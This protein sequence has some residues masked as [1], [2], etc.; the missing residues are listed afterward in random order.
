MTAC[1]KLVGGIGGNW[2][3]TKLNG[4][5]RGASHW[6]VLRHWAAVIRRK[7][8]GL[9]W[10]RRRQQQQHCNRTGEGKGRE[11]ARPPSSVSNTMSNQYSFIPLSIALRGANGDPA[12]SGCLLSSVQL[13]WAE[14]DRQGIRRAHP[15]ACSGRIVCLLTPW[16]AVPVKNL[17]QV[18]RCPTNATLFPDAATFR[19]H[20]QGACSSFCIVVIILPSLLRSFVNRLGC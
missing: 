14:T 7:G 1:G 12:L 20:K 15:S 8:F 5:N 16:T 2:G 18:T 3:N 19:C 11:R 9:R 10:M 4:W 17:L 6:P 13:L